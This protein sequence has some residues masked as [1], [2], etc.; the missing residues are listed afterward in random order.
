MG[1]VLGETSQKYTPRHSWSKHVFVLGIF[2]PTLFSS[3]F[4]TRKNKFPTFPK[5]FLKKKVDLS[6]IPTISSALFSLAI[7]FLSTNDQLNQGDL[8]S[9]K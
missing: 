6:N 1:P 7:L 8:A 2:H 9:L 3:S 4:F 5:Q